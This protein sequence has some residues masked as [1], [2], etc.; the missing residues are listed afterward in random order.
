MKTRPPAWVCGPR[1]IVVE[2]PCPRGDERVTCGLCAGSGGLSDARPE[3][4]VI[5]GLLDRLADLASPWGYVLVGVLALLE[6][7]AMIGLVVPGEAALLVGGFLASQDKAELPVMMAVAAVGAI[8]GDSIGYEIGKHLGPLSGAAGWAGGSVT[9]DGSGRRTTS[10]TTA[11][12]PCSS[13]GSSVCCG[14]WC[15]RWPGCRA[16]PTARSCPGTPSAG[17]CGRRASCSS[18]TWPAARTTRSP[19]GPGG[20]APSCSSWWCWWWWW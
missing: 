9:S 10:T 20:P 11:A 16:C 3:R 5:A 2:N 15:P 1:P 17:W 12:G 7:A 13:A 4:A 18:G 19:R 8:V 6:A 14:P